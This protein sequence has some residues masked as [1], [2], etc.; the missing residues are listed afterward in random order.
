[1]GKKFLLATEKWVERAFWSISQ[2]KKMLALFR[3]RE[4]GQITEPDRLRAFTR[5]GSTRVYIY[6]P[7][8]NPPLPRQ[9]HITIVKK[10]FSSI[11]FRPG[12]VRIET[13]TQR[14]WNVLIEIR[15]LS[16]VLKVGGT[17]PARS[18][19]NQWTTYVPHRHHR[20]WVLKAGVTTGGVLGRLRRNVVF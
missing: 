12:N 3:Q 20:G 10:E 19:R 6:Q 13:Q 4:L 2:K 17:C 14:Q 8:P 1:M 18:G 11:T 9:N 7:P 5:S 16:M 15:T